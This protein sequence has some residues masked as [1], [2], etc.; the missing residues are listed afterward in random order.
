[1]IVEEIPP[2]EPKSTY[3]IELT[4]E[5]ALAIALFLGGTTVKSRTDICSNFYDSGAICRLFN[6]LESSIGRDE[7]NRARK[8]VIGQAE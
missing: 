8:R 1:M 6:A 5:E 2:I 3:R 7:Y 4:E